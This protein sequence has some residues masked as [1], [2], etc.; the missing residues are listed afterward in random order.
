MSDRVHIEL[1]PLGRTIGVQKGDPLQDALFLQGAEFPCGGKG[2]CRGCRIRVLRGHL[3][4]TP[5]DRRMFSE[6][7]LAAGW[8]LACRAKAESDLT[9]ELAQWEAAILTDHAANFHFTPRAGLGVAVDLGT[10]TLVAQLLDLQ[11]GA[12]PRR[13]HGPERAG[14]TWG[15]CHEPHRAWPGHPGA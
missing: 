5:E 2:R 9:L 11:T 1:Q 7:E 15:R 4:V 10:T 13:A 3:P 14:Q 8:R 12:R 6:A